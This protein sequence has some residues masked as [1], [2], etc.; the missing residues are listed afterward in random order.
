MAHAALWV[1]ASEGGWVCPKP[2][3]DKSTPPNPVKMKR[4]GWRPVATDFL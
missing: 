2:M 4:L 3:D 1:H